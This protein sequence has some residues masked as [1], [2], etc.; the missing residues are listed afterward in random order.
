MPWWARFM[1]CNPCGASY[2]VQSMWCNTPDC[3]EVV[4]SNA[5]ANIPPS[6]HNL[7]G[8]THDAGGGG[9]TDDGVDDGILD[10][11]DRLRE[12]MM[13]VSVIRI[14]GCAR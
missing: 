7:F 9:A 1:W 11:E 12:S 13:Q 10:A 14:F 8:K 3:L 6:T 2:V 5:R 4:L